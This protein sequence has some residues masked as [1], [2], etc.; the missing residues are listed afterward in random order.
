MRQKKEL[1]IHL[2][3]YKNIL[4]YYIS[5]KYTLTCQK[6]LDWCLTSSW[7]SSCKRNLYYVLVYVVSA[8]IQ[9]FNDSVFH[10][11][12]RNANRF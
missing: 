10:T 4:I 8:K 9:R 7:N 2:Y 11:D 6:F 12:L 5:E 3:V 1:D